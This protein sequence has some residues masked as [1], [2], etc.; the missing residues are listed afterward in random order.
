MTRAGFL[1]QMLAWAE[2]PGDHYARRDLSGFRVSGLGFRVL[3][4]GF[5][6]QGLGF[7]A[8]SP[9][10]EGPPDTKKPP[11]GP[12]FRGLGFRVSGLGLG[13]RV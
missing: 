4:L 11:K 13:F 5:R 10:P 12:S 2:K 9:N 3:G 6:V 7:G 1:T 8:T